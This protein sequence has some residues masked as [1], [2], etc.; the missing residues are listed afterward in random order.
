MPTFRSLAAIAVTLLACAAVSAGAPVEFNGETDGP[1]PGGS[2]FPVVEDPV[3]GDFES[4]SWDVARLEFYNLFPGL[5]I[6]VDTVGP[7]DRNGGETSITGTTQFVALFTD[8]SG[9]WS[10]MIELTMTDT[11]KEL[12]IDG[13]LVEEGS[14]STRV[15]GAGISEGDLVLFIGPFPSW[16]RWEAGFRVQARLDDCDAGADDVI[17]GWVPEPAGLALLALGGLGLLRRRGRGRAL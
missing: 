11:T 3:E 9:S 7:F 17:V 4:P 13:V 15:W 16:S 10:H 2:Y 12:R 1:A 14:G 6:M 8:T 5:L